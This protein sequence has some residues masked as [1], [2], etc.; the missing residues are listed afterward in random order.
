MKAEIKKW[1]W[2]GEAT[3]TKSLLQDLEVVDKLEGK[4]GLSIEDLGCMG[5]S[6]SIKF[7]LTNKL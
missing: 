6:E 5:C 3:I 7:I 2:E 1:R 4:G